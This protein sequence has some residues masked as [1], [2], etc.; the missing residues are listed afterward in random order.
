VDIR[1]GD[2]PRAVLQL[3]LEKL[4]GHCGFAVRCN[5]DSEMFGE[6]THPRTIVPECGILQHRDR[7]R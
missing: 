6:T 4:R 1:N 5:P 2:A 3:L 7:Q